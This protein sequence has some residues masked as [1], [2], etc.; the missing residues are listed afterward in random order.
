MKSARIATLAVG[1]L[2]I[3]APARPAD[4]AAW[5]KMTALVGEWEGTYEGK[6]GPKV[7][8]RLVSN[9]TT[10][11]ETLNSDDSSEMVT[12]Y[13]RDGA[14]L[15]MTHYCSEGVQSRM[16]ASGL[17]GD[18]I[19]FAFLDATNVAGPDQHLMVG[20]RIKVPA[21][22]RLIHEWTSK[23]KGRETTGRFEFSRKR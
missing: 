15:A 4:D 5:A 23:H 21:A 17:S 19:Q 2:G 16:R 14:R 20:L 12:V 7:S 6:P 11:M 13:H 10:L 18:S 9:G 22:D 8:Y 3:G 1:L